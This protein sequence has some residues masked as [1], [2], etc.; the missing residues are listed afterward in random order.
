MALADAKVEA[1]IAVSDMDRAKEFYEGKLGLT[2][3]TDEED[4]GRT[5]PC[6]E[7]SQVHVFPS[8]NA[9]GSGATVAGWAV[10]DVEAEVEELSSNGVS[11]EQYGDPLNTDERGIANLPSGRGAWFKDPDGNVLGMF[12]QA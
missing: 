1:A 8:A 10:S 4:G 7:G 2:G 9:G 5:Y 3:G 11:F 6:G 12:E